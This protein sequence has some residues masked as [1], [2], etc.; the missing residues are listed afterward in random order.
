MTNPERLLGACA[1]VVLLSCSGKAVSRAQAS[2]VASH[3]SGA[4]EA[5]AS[6]PLDPF[7]LQPA[8]DQ[9]GVGAPLLER[10]L[11]ILAGDC[12]LGVEVAIGSVPVES[13][14]LAQLIQS[15]QVIPGSGADS[16]IVQRLR[17][18]ARQ[19]G[20]ACP[21]PGDV[22]LLEQFI[23]ALLLAPSAPCEPAPPLRYDELH[24]ALE[25]DLLAQPASDRQFQRYFALSYASNAGVC[26]ADFERE[27]SALFEAVNAV[28]IRA[29]IALPQAADEYGRA[30]RVDV[31]SYGWERPLDLGDVSAPQPFADGWQAIVS[32]AQPYNVEF[33]GPQANALKLGTETAVP[34][35]PAHAFIHAALQGDL[36]YALT[37]AERS[38]L[39]FARTRGVDLESTAPGAVIRAGFASG[40]SG[41][42]SRVSRWT[43][44][45]EPAGAFWVLEQGLESSVL[46]DPLQPFGGGLFIHGLPNG[47]PA[48]A[49]TNASGQRLGEWPRGSLGFVQ[50]T[51]GVN[52]G[53]CFACHG[54][55]SLPLRDEVRPLALRSP[56]LFSDAAS[57]LEQYPDSA[58]FARSLEQAGSR[59]AAARLD[60][61]VSPGVPDPL[62]Q[63]FLGFGSGL[64]TLQ[65]A[66]AEL[67]VAPSELRAVLGALPGLAPWLEGTSIDAWQWRA[68]YPRALCLV[69][70]AEQNA[71]LGCDAA[72]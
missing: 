39:E 12:G 7:A 34:L 42:T 22:A 49:V 48:F 31:R 29:A 19:P 40:A 66:A 20:V 38:F 6:A 52:G 41:V 5:G 21:R 25:R 68:L 44:S 65:Q 69:H 57:I 24:A 35:L 53:G 3:D 15:G 50:T 46:D 14:E 32:A 63:V 27:R 37:G 1:V 11:G 9:L 2:R 45:T 36:Y 13:G 23:D 64:V 70:A 26:G 4:P 8:L 61:G 60:T 33:S 10:A 51:G 62:A 18:Q 71:P 28:S 47:L 54:A 72:P 30:Y 59:Q 56:E 17:E 43:A 58:A 67:H 16:P 55:G